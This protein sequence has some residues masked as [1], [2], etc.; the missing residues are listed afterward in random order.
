[1]SSMYCLSLRS[2]AVSSLMIAGMSLPR[3]RKEHSQTTATRHPEFISACVTVASFILFR[4]ILS[5]QNSVRVPGSRKREQSCPCQKHPCTNTTARRPGNTMSGLPG[6]SRRLSRN[7]N[8]SLCR[9]L[10]MSFS[11]LVSRPR[12]PDI[13]L[14]RVAAST[15]S[16]IDHFDKFRSPII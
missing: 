4:P 9:R 16:A 7:L 1:M 8:P 2:H 3:P 12:I 15:I 10:R 14:L 13:I 5:D 11:G 6:R